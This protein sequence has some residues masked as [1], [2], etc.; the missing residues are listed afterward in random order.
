MSNE[1]FNDA[2]NKNTTASDNKASTDENKI[3]NFN[4]K[5]KINIVVNYG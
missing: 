1:I 3:L 5:K 2:K 4:E